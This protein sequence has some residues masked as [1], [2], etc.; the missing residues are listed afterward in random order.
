MDIEPLL[1]AEDCGLLTAP[2]LYGGSFSDGETPV[3]Q[4]FSTPGGEV[5]VALVRG[6]DK[7]GPAEDAAGLL[8]VANGGIVLLVADGVG[9]WTMMTTT[10][11]PLFWTG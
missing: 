7:N 6:P 4:C 11:A 8:P 10:C 5:A 3:A 1:H 9:R 2:R